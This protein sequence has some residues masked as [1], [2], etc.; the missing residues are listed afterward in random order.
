MC[1]TLEMTYLHAELIQLIVSQ[2]DSKLKVQRY[3]I[4]KN[5]VTVDPA[6]WIV[7][8]TTW[9]TIP[10]RPKLFFFENR[11]AETEFSVFEFWGRFGF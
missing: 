11:T 4:K 5:I 9:K 1:M 7:N 8:E 3:N 6:R 10:K 2:S